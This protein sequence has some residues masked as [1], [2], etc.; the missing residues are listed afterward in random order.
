MSHVDKRDPCSFFKETF[1]QLPPD[2]REKLVAKR[3]KGAPISFP[4][5]GV[6]YLKRDQFQEMLQLSIRE[7]MNYR[8][9]GRMAEDAAKQL[10]DGINLSPSLL[11][12]PEDN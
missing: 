3:M 5:S 12:A 10:F 2:E 1:F 11:P 6:R 4:I 9:H 7:M 8:I